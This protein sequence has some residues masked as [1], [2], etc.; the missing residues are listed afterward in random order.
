MLWCRTTDKQSEWISSKTPIQSE[1]LT[2]MG[3]HPEPAKKMEP[4]GT[5]AEMWWQYCQ[6]GTTW[7]Q[8]RRGRKLSKNTWCFRKIIWK[9]CGLS[10]H[11][12][13]ET[14][15]LWSLL[16]WEG[17]LAC[18]VPFQITFLKYHVFFD[19]FLPLTTKQTTLGHECCCMITINECQAWS[20]MM[21]DIFVVNSSSTT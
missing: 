12:W 6:A 7:L 21:S 18:V 3:V 2:L 13:N 11:F 4:A 8:G 20:L 9:N 14:G 17:I 10:T 5:H 16:Y 1:T 19:S 15:A